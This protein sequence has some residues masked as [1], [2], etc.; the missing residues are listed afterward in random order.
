MMRAFF[1]WVLGFI[2]ATGFIWLISMFCITDISNRQWN[3]DV[4]D[5]IVKGRRCI[6]DEGCGCVNFSPDGIIGTA[7]GLSSTLPHVIIWGDSYVESFNVGDEWAVYHQLSV[8][9]QKSTFPCKGIAVAQSG[10]DISH[11]I[12]LMPYYNQ[13]VPNIRLHVIVFTLNDIL[14]NGRTLVADGDVPCQWHPNMPELM[15]LRPW[16]QHYDLDWLWEVLNTSRTSFQNLRIS[17]GPVKS[18]SLPPNIAQSETDHTAF[19]EKLL[20]QLRESA[21]GKEVLLVYHAYCPQIKDGWVDFRDSDSKQ[22]ESFKS[23]CR[24]QSIPVLALTEQF[25]DYYRCTGRFPRG[26]CNSFPGKGHWNRAG[27]RLVAQA[28]LDYLQSFS[29]KHD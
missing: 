27:H 29:D 11:H 10:R 1:H 13:K 25:C 24:Q 14:P 18:R 21:G 22:V 4:G 7:D 5:Y 26:F 28:I 9:S 3:P 12:L 6:Y 23:L 15:W 2:L 16:I 17:I 8:L 20:R 19:W